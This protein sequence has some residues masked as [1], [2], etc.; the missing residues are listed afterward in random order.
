MITA[1]IIFSRPHSDQSNSPSVN[2]Q[3]RL[4]IF[5]VQ[6]ENML[7]VAASLAKKRNIALIG[8]EMAA[9]ILSYR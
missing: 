4:V 1:A 5:R 9:F 7:P 2:L 6:V 8:L 3:P